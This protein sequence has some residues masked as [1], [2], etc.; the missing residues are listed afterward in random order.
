[1]TWENRRKWRI[2]FVLPIEEKGIT[3]E[4]MYARLN[5]R[6]MVPRWN[7]HSGGRKRSRPTRE[8]MPSDT[9]SSAEEA[10]SDS[11]DGASSPCEPLFIWG[12]EWSS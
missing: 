2:A 5:Y 6:N 8:E 4:E 1:M 11:A 3:T 9:A 12:S 7:S 10:P